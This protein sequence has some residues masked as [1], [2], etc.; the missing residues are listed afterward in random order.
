MDTVLYYDHVPRKSKVSSKYTCVLHELHTG[1]D[2][3]FK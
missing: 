3:G 2:T 1:A